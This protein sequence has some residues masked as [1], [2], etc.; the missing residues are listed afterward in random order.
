MKRS[1][2]LVA[3]VVIGSILALPHP[4]SARDKNAEKTRKAGAVKVYR[5]D[6]LDIEGHV[7]TPQ[8]M[9][10]FKRVRNRF[11]AHR[12][13]QQKFSPLVLKNR[14]AKFLR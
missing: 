11:R 5:F 14:N 1:D 2:M 3:L 8:I 7:K 4:S 10:F 6:D 9:V 12:L 13:K